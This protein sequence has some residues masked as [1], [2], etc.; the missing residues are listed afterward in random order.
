MSAKKRRQPYGDINIMKENRKLL[1][2]VL[3]D[4]RQDMS[5]EEVLN[6]LANRKISVRPESEKNI[7]WGNEPQTL[8]QNL[9]AVGHSFFRL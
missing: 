5:D 4:I 1:K 7:L 9:Q 6:L 2:D 8:S 3:D